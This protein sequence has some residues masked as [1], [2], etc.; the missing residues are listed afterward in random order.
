MSNP[1]SETTGNR[2]RNTDVANATRFAKQMKDTAKFDPKTETWFV[3]DG[4]RWERQGGQAKLLRLAKE[5]ALSIDLEVALET[6]DGT[7]DQL[8]AWARASQAETKLK[9]MISLARAERSL[10]VSEADFDR[11]PYLVNFLNGN[12]NIA[13]GEFL[14]EHDPRQMLTKL[15]P[16]RYSPGAPCPTFIQVLTR[17]TLGYGED[18]AEFLLRALGYSAMVNGNPEQVAFFFKGDPNTGKSMIAEMVTELVGG[19]LGK[20]SSTA[21]LARSKV[22]THHD[23]ELFSIRGKQF[24]FLDETDNTLVL[25]EQR[26]KAITGGATTEVRQL[27]KGETQSVRTSWTAFVTT[28]EMMSVAAWDGGVARRIIMIPSGPSIPA[29]E[30]NQDIK[31]DIRDEA[32]G[33]LAALISGARMWFIKRRDGVGSGFGDR[34]PAVV[35][36]TQEVADANDHVAAFVSARVEFASGQRAKTT[37]VWSA[38]CMFVSSR[39]GNPLAINDPGITNT[40]FYKNLVTECNRR[41]LM[42]AKDARSFIH[43][44]IVG[45]RQEDAGPVVVT[46]AERIPDYPFQM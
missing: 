30:V 18:T 46:P 34:P 13:S 44:R 16:H 10:W 31:E 39:T 45:E 29:H 15:I 37:D 28:N 3:W 40:A 8:R 17:A 36:A 11:D 23:S 35:V 20:R 26:F 7:R 33:V 5:V 42:I 22:G 32:E 38:Y 25:D 12:Y 24:V 9:A 14:T 19:D 27:Y 2:L 43:L 21:L 6:D 41:G 1:I 4:R